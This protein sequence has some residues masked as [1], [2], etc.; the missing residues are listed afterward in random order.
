M[1]PFKEAHTADLLKEMASL[2]P[3]REALIHVKRGKRY[4]HN[5]LLDEVDRLAK[6]LLALGVEKGEHVALWAPNLP[7]WVIAAFAIARVGAVLVSVDPFYEAPQL[8]YLLKNSESRTLILARGLDGGEGFLRLLEGL[9]PE[10]KAP[11]MPPHLERFPHLKRLILLSDSP[12][13]GILCLREVIER[14][15]EISNDE[16]EGRAA[17]CSPHDI[18]TLMY[19]SGTTGSPKGV[20]STH[21]ALINK[22]M[23]SASL[24]KLGPQDRLCLAV[25]LFPMFG[26]ICVLLTAVTCGATTV[27]PSDTFDAEET[28][29]AIE[30]ERCTALYG[31]PSLFVSL[32]EHPR[33]GDFDL[34]TLRKGIVAGAPCPMELMKR[35]VERM[36]A[37]DMITGYG[38]TEAST[39]ITMTSAD[40]P[41]EVR[42]ST[43]GRALPHIEV[44]IIDPSSGEELPDG[45]EGEICTRGLLM[46]GYYKMPAATAQAID[47]EGWLHTGDLGWKGSDGLFRITGRVK[48]LIRKGDRM[49]HPVEVEEYLYTHPK[50]AEAQVFGVPDEE[51]GEEIAAW[52]KLKEGEEAT[53][54]EIFTFCREGLDPFLIPKYVRFVD[55]FPMTP[56]KKVQKFKLRQEAMKLYGLER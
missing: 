13:G 1:V 10:I 56:T 7:E 42:I 30:R 4:T 8:E 18:F 31:T 16:L 50:I 12:Y 23:I 39:W 45:A 34:S 38:L 9:A 2:F 5:Q 52:I 29:K 43:I 54:E 28:L 47:K 17:L 49:I 3:E 21:Y 44:K 35:I 36:G 24:Q 20:L 27:I 25:P 48:E 51:V 19:T 37:K 53:E 6:G 14:G 26:S 55:S 11:S 32:L 46:E 41:L 22:S 15:E 40:D 33:F